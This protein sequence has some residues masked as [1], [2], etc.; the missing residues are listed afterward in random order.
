MMARSKNLSA[1][2]VLE[3]DKKHVLDEDTRERL[4]ALGYLG[5]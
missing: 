1:Q 4:K 2:F 5:E 3:P